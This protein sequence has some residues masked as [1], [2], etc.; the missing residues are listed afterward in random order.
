[1]GNIKPKHGKS[2]WMEKIIFSNQEYTVLSR[3][4]SSHHLRLQRGGGEPKDDMMTRGRGG[5]L[6]TPQKWWRHLW[7]APYDYDYE[8]G[9]HGGFRISKEMF[10][11]VIFLLKCRRVWSFK[12]RKPFIFIH[13]YV[14]FVFACLKPFK[15]TISVSHDL[16]FY[17]SCYE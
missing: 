16:H 3:I 11:T 10:V 12:P 14:L 9:D 17:K 7:T 13:S 2:I 15:N 6:D 8:G 4:N 1:M 5:G